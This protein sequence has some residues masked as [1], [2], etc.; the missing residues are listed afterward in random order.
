MM[1]KVVS[2]LILLSSCLLSSTNPTSETTI[3]TRYFKWT[4]ES[5]ID[6]V[7]SDN[8]LREVHVQ[9]WFPTTQPKTSL[10]KASYLPEFEKAAPQLDQLSAETVRLWN[11][12][13]TNAWQAT[14]I[15][16][17]RQKY[18]V[19]LISPGLGGHSSFFTHYAEEAVKRGYVVVGV[20]HKYESA[21]IVRKNGDVLPA[22]HRFQDRIKS[23]RIPEDISADEYRKK[24]GTRI[25][26]LGKD[27]VF[28]L[29]KLTEINK[30]N[31]DGRLSL[32]KV[33]AFGHSY[34]GGAAI[35]ASRFDKRFQ[36]VINI[37][38]TPSYDALNEGTSVPL[39][40]LEDLQENKSRGSKIVNKRRDDFCKLV[41]ADCFRVLMAD[42][43]HNSF[44]D[45]NLHSNPGEESRQ[46]ID[47][48]NQ[49]MLGFFDKYLLNQIGGFPPKA[50]KA[51]KIRSFVKTR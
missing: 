6:A 1:F 21:Y 25:E 35:D 36:A 29:D 32:K 34:G 8:E 38:G 16:K 11:N 47:A 42:S 24:R 22:D 23:L 44:L 31:F 19:L 30:E 43:N 12:I 14:E 45:T 40:F 3:G 37:D 39:M 17:E 10:T 5:R 27:L 26:V 4:D 48:S 20:N 2:I 15:S 7:Y 46:I 28:V 13:P 18:P 41:A 51:T 33:G 50:T 49:A 9:V